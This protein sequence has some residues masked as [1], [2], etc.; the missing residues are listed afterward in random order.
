MRLLL[1][2][3]DTSLLAEMS[4]ILSRHGHS[5]D[6]VDNAEDAVAVVKTNRY[7]F[8]LVDYRMP[9]HDGIWFLQNARLPRHTTTLLV[10]S[11]TDGAVIRQM[12]GAGISGYVTKPFDENE[13]LMH[14]EFHS[15]NHRTDGKEAEV[16]Q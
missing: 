5:V 12:F 16:A 3:D 2:D 10:T 14:L 7:D 15:K 8:V 13:L 11:L 4:R 6:C 9:K 1:V